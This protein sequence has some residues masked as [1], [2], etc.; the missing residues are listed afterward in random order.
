MKENSKTGCGSAWIRAPGSGPGGRGF[1][2]RRPDG[3]FFL[4]RFLPLLFF[5]SQIPPSQTEEGEIPSLAESILVPIPEK[6]PD[7]P[8]ITVNRNLFRKEDVLNLFLPGKREFQKDGE[9]EIYS[10]PDGKEVTFY[11][12][13]GFIY[14]F[15]APPMK[16]SVEIE[17]AEKT[18]RR[19]L[20]DF[21]GLPADAELMEK[22]TIQAGEFG[23]VH[24]FTFGHKYHDIPVESDVIRVSVIGNHVSEL[25]FF[26]SQVEKETKPTQIIHA[27]EGVRKAW[28]YFYQVIF[29]NRYRIPNQVVKL[30]LIYFYKSSKELD[31]L[32]P[33]WRIDLQARM[34]EFAEDGKQRYR[35]QIIPVRINALTGEAVE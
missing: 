21:G 30:E 22:G 4:K 31:K 16:H 17:K 15:P 3:R 14:V 28:L 13:M 23:S 5:L 7:L 9:L 6:R 11:P 2:S 20:E 24:Y 8:E 19:F 34:T 26:W 35:Y 1:K 18:A 32:V 12:K 29:M 10:H 33:V 27:M 25:V